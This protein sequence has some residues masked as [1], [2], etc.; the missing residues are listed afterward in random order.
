MVIIFFTVMLNVVKKENPD[1]A[2]PF[3]FKIFPLLAVIQIGAGIVGLISGINFLKLKS[4]SRT[5]LEILT[6]LLLIYC[7]GFGIFWAFSW[8]SHNI[9]ES[10]S[11]FTI[12]GVVMGVMI[13]CIYGVPLFIM[14]KYLRG[15]KVKTAME[16]AAQQA[17][18]T[19]GSSAGN[20]SSPMN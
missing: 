13:I 8:I 11:G 18:S 6:W 1:A 16:K 3:F 2:F 17:D 15:N 10:P 20:P 7:I 12:I 19:Y 4:W 9:E 14:L 5:V